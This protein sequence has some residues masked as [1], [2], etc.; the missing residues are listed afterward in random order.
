MKS[1]L[2]PLL[3]AL[4]LPTAVK[5][6]IDPKVRKACLPAADFEGCV[7]A[8]TNPKEKKRKLDFLGMEPIP[9]WR[10]VEDRP[11]NTIWYANHK[12][13]RK[14]KVRGLYGRYITYEYVA[15]FYQ[16]Y[17]PGRSGSS[18]TIGSGTTNCY[19]YGSSMSCTTTPP[20]TINI[21]G[22][23]STPA[24]VR[25]NKRTV[26][27]DCLERQA[28]WI[29]GDKKWDSFEGKK[30]TQPIADENCSKVDSL[31][32]SNYLKWEKGKPNQQD[33]LAQ[34]ILPGSTPQEVRDATK[35]SNARK[36]INCKSPVWKNKPQCK[37]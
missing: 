7:N 15:R 9:G 16:D 37:L 29:P 30:V 24:G 3:A 8:Y 18:T 11:D 13:V 32:V 20:A 19:G 26:M 2:L 5:G 25:Q 6:E 21:P 12:D 10:V 14:V 17:V 22:R 31:K 33:L 35:S 23:A 34:E 4:V 27:I 28:K 36:G 1:F